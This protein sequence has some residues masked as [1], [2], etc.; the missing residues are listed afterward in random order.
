MEQIVNIPISELTESPFNHRQVF[1]ESSLQELAAD[2]KAQGRV[3]S[4]LLIRPT[5]TNTLRMDVEPS[6]GHEI[7]FG[8]RRYR[9]AKIAG[10]AQI[11]C[12]VRRMTTEEVKRAQISENLQREDVHPIEEAEGFQALMKDHGVTA[13][14]LVEQTGKSRSYIYGRLVLLK[15][16]PEV[17]RACL[18]G[19][20]GSEV[21]LLLAR[22]RTDKLQT[23]A[24]AQIKSKYY[25]L[26][27]G[28]EKSYRQIRELLKENFTLELKGAMFDTG[29]MM[30]LPDAGACTT[31]PKRAGNAPEYDDLA[32]DRKSNYGSP[33]KGSADI[34]TDP[35]CFDAKKKAHLRAAAAA[36]ESNGKTVIEGNK[37]RAAVS[38]NGEV[39]GAYV[40]LKDVKSALAKVKK[41][42][43]SLSGAPLEIATVLIQDP[44]T[45]K[46]HE[47]VEVKELQ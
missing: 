25:N 30:L 9:A 35:D 37:A 13:E 45:G 8:H 22:L 40:A 17:R 19:E 18:R 42:R 14:Q 29:D 10:L 32:S 1:N 46:T 7:V 21:A 11:P 47:A 39:K 31:C 5:W 27:D 41:E 28:G 34:C 44:R 6:D 3:L 15:A 38:A 24:L 4:P 26:E 16:C 23:K 33:I 20:V 43:K 2:I 36:L 12:M